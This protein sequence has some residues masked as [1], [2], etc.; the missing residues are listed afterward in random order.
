M[1]MKKISLGLMMSL[2][3][4]GCNS[5][6]QDD[7]S[8]E[9]SSSFKAECDALSGVT[10]NHSEIGLPSGNAI[11]KSTQFSLAK[12]DT[13]NPD[14]TAMI[15]A[16]PDY[17]QVM[18]QIQPVDPE[19]PLIN[20][21]VNLPSNWNEK[22]L[23]YGGSGYNGTLITGL[24]GSRGAGPDVPLPL[25]QGYVTSGTDS[26][27]Q[28]QDGVE[29]QA[30]ALNEEALMN[31]AYAAYKKTHDIAEFITKKY[32]G[33]LPGKSYYMG[34]SEGGREGMMMAQRFP[35]DYDGIIAIDPVMNWSSLQTFGNW[36]GGILQKSP[37]AW[38]GGKTQ[39]IH[40]TVVGACDGLD[41]IEDQVVSNYSACATE[42]KP[43]I[44]A[45][46]CNVN[47]IDTSQCLSQAQLE[48]VHA[49]YTG[50]Q[51][52]F[53]LAHGVTGYAGLGYGGEGISSNWERW[54]AGTLAPQ[55]PAVNEMSGIY[56]YGSGY[57][58]YFIA[59]DPKFNTLNYNP[60]DF[61]DRVKHISEAIDAYNPDLS[62][63]YARG[64]KIILRENLADKGQ[65]P[66][67]GLNYWQQVSE[68]MGKDIIEQFF[69]AYV[70]PGLPHTSNGIASGSDNAPTYGIPGRV[71]LLAALD[72][73]VQTG[74]KPADSLIVKQYETL[75]PYNVISSKPMCRYSSYPKFNGDLTLMAKAEG[76]SCIRNQ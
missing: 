68:K 5:S 14:K 37:E 3:L 55:F 25:T 48:V 61:K 65:S 23:Q 32:Y 72:Q 46:L 57:I 73:W 67:S 63:F 29:V 28:L 39:L 34:G 22:M 53:E 58:R 76:Y 26:G 47:Q 10:I 21:Q 38:L 40:K 59:Q 30:F 52:D 54:V 24:D 42:A 33:K 27:H 13:L 2:G 8:N 20:A 9:Q 71:D 7:I 18:V 4:I 45:L 35:E 6:D 1:E 49:A 56:N 44:D 70:V 12:E 51:F 31:H 11:I 17:C 62:K 50:Y 43:A 15:Q 60:S 75:P 36:L 19:A 16:T 41:G 69:V 74:K 66:Y 64:G